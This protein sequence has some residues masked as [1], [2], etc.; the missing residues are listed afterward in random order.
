VLPISW[1]Q[2]KTFNGPELRLKVNLPRIPRLPAKDGGLA[3][4]CELHALAER[5][6]GAEKVCIL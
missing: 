4:V 5:T 3:G 6:G 2:K 1:E